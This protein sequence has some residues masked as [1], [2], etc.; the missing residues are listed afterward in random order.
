M[1]TLYDSLD[2]AFAVDYDFLNADLFFLIK[3]KTEH[4]S[5]LQVIVIQIIYNLI[6]ST[7]II[8]VST[9]YFCFNHILFA[10][11]IY[12]NI[13]S[14]QTAGTGLYIIISYS[15]DNG[16]KIKEKIPSALFFQKSFLSVSI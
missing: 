1:F 11:I 6:F 13:C 4:I 9:P 8:F 14:S 7:G 3:V 12:D 15:V 2:K 5:G 16:A 10:A